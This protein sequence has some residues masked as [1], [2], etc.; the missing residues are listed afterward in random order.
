MIRLADVSKRYSKLDEQAMLL[1][2][3]VP[4]WRPNRTVLWALRD[5]G[6]TIGRGETVGIIGHN[7]AGKTT[8]L[9][10]LAGVTQ[11]SRGRVLVSGRIA[12]LISVGVGFHKE[13]SGRENVYV[14]G[15]LLGLT[16]AEIDA[17]F[18][19]IVD[20]AGLEEFI[21]TPVKF[22][23]SGM[24]MRL[25]FAVAVC[26][27]PDV[28][29]VDEILAVGD[30][31]FQLKCFERLREIQARGATIVMVSHWTH[32]VRLLCPRTVLLSEG[33]LV[34]DGDTQEAISLYHELLSGGVGTDSGGSVRVLRRTLLGAGG[35]TFHPRPDERVTY[36]TRLAFDRPIDSPQMSFEIISQTGVVV[37]GVRTFGESWRRFESGETVDVGVDFLCRLGGDTYRLA[38]QIHDRDGNTVYVDHEGLLMYGAPRAGTYG[39]VDLEAAVHMGGQRLTHELDVLLGRNGDGTPNEAQDDPLGSLP[40]GLR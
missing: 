10:L 36:I 40:E 34:Y 9:R 11:P 32:A 31:L 39:V 20:F 8:L 21:D 4:W 1:R 23:S 30:V 3:I 28:L 38:I 29:L 26:S 13:M 25:G 6:L 19:E 18:D 2:S 22:Y 12:P 15:M 14:N 27:D 16:R 17:R 35:P 24:F 5:I 7:G 37:Y 33:Q